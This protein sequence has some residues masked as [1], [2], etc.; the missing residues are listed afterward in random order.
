MTGR[1]PIVRFFRHVFSGPWLLR[2]YFPAAAMRNIEAAIRQSEAGHSGEVRFVV[3]PALHPLEILRGEKPRE[4]ALEIFARLGVWDTEHN[5]GVLIYL[6]LADHDVEI[7]ADRSIHGHVGA[8]GWEAIC[9]E[10]EAA[11]RQGS[12]EGGVTQGI[13]RIGALLQQ[14]FPAA[15]AN[16][17]ELPDTPI[18][19]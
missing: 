4:R 12:F 1:N 9:Q 17:N 10:M 11:F 18:V 16:A 14:H 19:L 13:V 7:V 6:L 15:A 8:Q 3:E 2:R 5:N